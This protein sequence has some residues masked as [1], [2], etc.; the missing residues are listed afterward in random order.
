MKT[1]LLRVSLLL[2]SV[3]STTS[4]VSSDNA[5]VE[6]TILELN[7]E[8]LERIQR[9][10]DREQRMLEREDEQDWAAAHIRMGRTFHTMLNAQEESLN[11]L[12]ERHTGIKGVLKSQQKKNEVLAWVAQER[13]ALATKR[14]LNPLPATTALAEVT[15]DVEFHQQVGLFLGKQ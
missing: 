10:Q 12:E 2:C 7:Q 8:I 4:L 15:H 1:N 11:D 13:A 9:I 6:K 14:S 5:P 3:V